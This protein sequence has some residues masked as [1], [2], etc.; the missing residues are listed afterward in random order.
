MNIKRAHQ[1]HCA[2]A[3]IA[4]LASSYNARY[5]SN[6][7]IN[8]NSPADA[9]EIYNRFMEE[10][11]NIASLLDTKALNAPYMRWE[12]WWES[13]DVMNLGLV[14]ELASAALRLVEHIACL[15]AMGKNPDNEGSVCNLQETI[16]GMLHPLARQAAAEGLKGGYREAM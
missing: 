1:I 12:K 9:H 11:S 10:Q 6:T 5:G 3:N 14:N 8:D 4:E 2:L 13:R 15:E 16:A 7:R